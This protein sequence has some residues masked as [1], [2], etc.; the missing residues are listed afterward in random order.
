[1]LSWGV[2]QKLSKRLAEMLGRQAAVGREGRGQGYC[3]W[4]LARMLKGLERWLSS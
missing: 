4:M 3:V 1:M 2:G